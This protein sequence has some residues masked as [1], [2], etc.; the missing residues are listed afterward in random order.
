MAPSPTPHWTTPVGVPVPP[1]TKWS[2]RPRAR[3]HSQSED[4][5]RV[6]AATKAQ[7]RLPR[8]LVGLPELTQALTI[9]APFT[10]GLKPCTNV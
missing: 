2:S 1:T 7:A 4:T 6:T 3:N 5:V 9:D 10:D 8:E